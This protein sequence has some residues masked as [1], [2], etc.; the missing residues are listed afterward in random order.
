MPTCILLNELTFFGP[1]ILCFYLVDGD[2]GVSWWWL[3]CLR[4]MCIHP[5]NHSCQNCCV[6]IFGRLWFKT[7][8]QSTPVRSVLRLI[9]ISCN[10]L[11]VGDLWLFRGFPL[12]QF[13]SISEINI[14][15]DKYVG[16]VIKLTDREYNNNFFLPVVNVR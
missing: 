12:F 13:F 2:V 16:W 5:A 3:V 6:L 8:V 7:I 4:T 14:I 15:K 11:A 1:L 10:G 9:C